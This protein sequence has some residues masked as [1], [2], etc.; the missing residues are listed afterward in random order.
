MEKKPL[1]LVMDFVLNV[2]KKLEKVN[3]Q[4]KEVKM[5]LRLIRKLLHEDS[6]IGELLIDGYFECYTLEDKVR[7]LGE[8]IPGRTAIPAGTYK[9]VIDQSD[10][11]Q[12]L[13]PHLLDVPN[14]DGIRI[15]SGN[16][17]KDTE[18][19]ILVGSTVVNENFIGNSKGV[20]DQL[21]AK[22]KSTFDLGEEVSI[23]VE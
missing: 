22:L 2:L 19:C 8:K 15:H 12:R 6:T 1:K 16:T 17:D 5:K 23:T 21:F 7:P 10:R 20:F 3:L 13:M 18:G 4:K 14:F 11:F 9:L